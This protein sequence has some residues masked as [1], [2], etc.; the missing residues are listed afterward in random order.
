M[1]D[2]RSFYIKFSSCW[3]HPLGCRLN[4]LN[5]IKAF[6][7]IQTYFLC[8]PGNY[9]NFN[10]LFLGHGNSNNWI[11][12]FMCRDWFYF[13]F[14]C[15]ENPISCWVSQTYHRRWKWWKNSH[16]LLVYLAYRINYPLFRWIHRA[17]RT[18]PNGTEKY[19]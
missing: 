15:D 16:S 8:T 10:C 1:S 4:F 6:A 3:K 19:H 5:I 14:L 17:R 18:I 13:L 12:S 11:K 7:I 2:K 9:L